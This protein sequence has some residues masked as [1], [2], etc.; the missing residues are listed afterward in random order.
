MNDTCSDIESVGRAVKAA[1][2]RRIGIDGV[3]GEGDA[4][5]AGRTV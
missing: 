3:D 4:E 2:W 5:Q 1:E